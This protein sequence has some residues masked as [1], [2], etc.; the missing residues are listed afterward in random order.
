MHVWDVL[1]VTPPATSEPPLAIAACRAGAC[2][3]I[4][5][6]F[7]RPDALASVRRLAHF[8]GAPFGVKV[9]PHGADLLNH[10][11]DDRPSNLRR[12]ILA[13]GVFP[14]AGE[15]VQRLREQGLEVL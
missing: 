8:A 12:V 6:E 10:V 9:G 15:W 13:G 11:L 3:V 2:G 7:E 14:D 4:D 1:A 5:L